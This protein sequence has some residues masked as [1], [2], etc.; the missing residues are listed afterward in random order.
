[1]EVKTENL[2]CVCEIIRGLAFRIRPEFSSDSK[3]LLLQSNDLNHDIYWDGIEAIS[4]ET[5]S[6]AGKELRKYDIVFNGRGN[7]IKTLLVEDLPTNKTVY[8]AA[9][10]LVIR[11][12]YDKFRKAIIKE[13]STHNFLSDTANAAKDKLELHEYR[14]KLMSSYLSWYLNSELA[15]IEFKQL[16]GGNLNKHIT[17]RIM[18]RFP[19]KI[20]TETSFNTVVKY[21]DKLNELTETSKNLLACR[22]RYLEL[23]L[24]Q[25]EV[26]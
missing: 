9:P 24:N 5:D 20:P 17:K 25:K 18:R 14:M 12:D 22:N 6:K 8:V 19:I 15:Q 26:K 1:M 3:V 10:I 4:L 13:S 7:Q 23:K 2:E 21:I 11:P 16:L